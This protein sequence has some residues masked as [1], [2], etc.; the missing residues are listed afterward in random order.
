M[1]ALEKWFLLC[2]CVRVRL[3]EFFRAFLA[4]LTFNPIE[5]LSFSA[6]LSSGETSAAAAAGTIV[7]LVAVAFLHLYAA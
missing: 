2:D 3:C 6:K 5:R 1:C 4:A 7:N